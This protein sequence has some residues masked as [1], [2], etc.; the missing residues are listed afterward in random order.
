MND[1]VDSEERKEAGAGARQ[2]R[3]RRPSNF[4]GLPAKS[5]GEWN[6]PFQPVLPRLLLGVAQTFL[7]TFT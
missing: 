5:L 1:G 4:F 7:L 6:N 3:Y 2:V